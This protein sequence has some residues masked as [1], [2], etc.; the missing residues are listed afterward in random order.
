MACSSN[1]QN[2]FNSL[3]KLAKFSPSQSPYQDHPNRYVD[4]RS[5]VQTEVEIG[6]I[7]IPTPPH[8]L[9]RLAA[10]LVLL[11]LLHLHLSHSHRISIL[12]VLVLLVYRRQR[13]GIPSR[14]EHHL[15]RLH[16]VSSVYVQRA[17]EHLVVSV[18]VAHC[19]IQSVHFFLIF[20]LL[21]RPENVSYALF[22][23]LPMLLAAP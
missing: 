5:L 1:R 21:Q 15:A 18:V 20:L 7:I 9:H 23:S 3:T 6:V 10:L 14:I 17:H 12:V 19:R 8:A 11:A 22:V 16:V 4:G 2:R 13:N